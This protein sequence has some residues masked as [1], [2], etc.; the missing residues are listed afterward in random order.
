MNKLTE[1]EKY[2]RLLFDVTP[3]PALVYD[4]S[5]F[6]ILN[7]N[8]AAVEAYGYSRQEF[9][10]LTLDRLLDP[11]DVVRVKEMVHANPQQ[12]RQ[13]ELWKHCRRN[14]ELFDVEINAYTVELETGLV[15]LVIVQDI[16]ERLQSDA[17]LR[18]SERH[19]R[20]LYEK[21]NDAIYTHDLQGNF[22][23][24]N[25]AGE[26]FL[27]YAHK[28]LLG[29]NIAELLPSE[30]LG[31][32]QQMISMKM[33]GGSNN[34]V[35][36]TKV[37]TKDG[38]YLTAEIS[39]TLI[40]Q[41][42]KPVGVQG[43]ARDMTERKRMEDQIRQVEK[44]NAVGR[45]AGGVAH[46]FNNRLTAIMGFTDLLLK[47]TDKQDQHHYY[48]EQIKI[49]SERAT[50]LTR[51]LLTFSRKQIL[52]PELL[53]LNEAVSDWGNLVR[54]LLGENIEIQIILGSEIG[55]IKADPSQLEHVIMNLAINACD[56]MPNGGEFTIA[57]TDIEISDLQSKY[58]PAIPPGNYVRL[59]V[60]DT[61]CGMSQDTLSHL[62]EPFFTTKERGKG[63]GLGL[64]TAYGIIK[65]SG[66]YVEVKSAIGEGTSFLIYL[67][68]VAGTNI[69]STK[70]IAVPPVSAKSETILLVEDDPSVR[71]LVC[72]VLESAG[73]SV[74]QAEQGQEAL[75][76]AMKYAGPIDLTVTD[77]R[78]PGMSGFDM[79]ERLKIFRPQMRVLFMSAYTD[80]ARVT[81]IA[82]NL[83]LAFLQKPF[84][85]EALVQEVQ[86]LLMR[87]NNATA[88]A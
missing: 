86:A 18:E 63:T 32:A 34:T 26:R 17:K 4:L 60:K 7:V 79:I 43:I 59:L 49:A 67:P 52:Q 73:Y 69:S 68:V 11:R 44:M 76:F 12:S 83:N 61:G 25:E 1:A 38:Q 81:S 88:T 9:S 56:A 15:R 65:Q 14:G 5:D 48:L 53:N 58:N 27:G 6:S 31:R 23:S 80:D 72:E 85:L 33:V 71:T 74:L 37:R 39:S 78:M 2:Y 42:G 46:D 13:K 36:E 3:L 21:A 64:F 35:Y 41:E 77:V 16:S 87:T 75:D 70:E 30:D 66:G 82:Q 24:M 10:Q 55:L 54:V 50:E 22:T 28:E 20:E 51:Q 84:T 47:R 29:M 45:L 62:F 8:E 19:Y 57:T 40:Y